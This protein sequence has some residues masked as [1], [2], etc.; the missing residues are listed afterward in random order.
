[1]NRIGRS[2]GVADPAGA[3]SSDVFVILHPRDRWRKGVDH[4]A[5]VDEMARRLARRV[6]AT[7][8]RIQPTD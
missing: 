2:E 8:N 1:M 6:P 7:I 3:E 5:L 4:E